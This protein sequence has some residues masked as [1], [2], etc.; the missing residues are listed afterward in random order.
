MNNPVAVVNFGPAETQ[1]LIP[2]SY[3][4]GMSDVVGIIGKNKDVM[5]LIN[6]ANQKGTITSSS[7][8]KGEL[9]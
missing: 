1:A 4:A 9:D 6:Y 5:R 3:I 2:L 7:N 8:R